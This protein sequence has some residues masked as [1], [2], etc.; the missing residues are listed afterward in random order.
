[1]QKII[2]FLCFLIQTA[3]FS[4]VQLLSRVQLFST[5]WTAA[6]QASLSFTIS[7]SLLKL[8]SIKSMMPSNHLILCHP[9]SSHLQSFPASGFFQMSQFFASGDQSIGASALA[10]VLPMN[11]LPNPQHQSYATGN[12]LSVSV[13]L[14]ILDI[15]RRWNRTVCGL[16][17]W[18]SHTYYSV[19]R[20]IYFAAGNCTS[21]LFI[22]LYAY[23]TNPLISL[24]AFG[25]ILAF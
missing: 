10:S 19:F 9:L 12:L 2:Y 13:A 21:F 15:L 14:P 1:M 17:W 20:Y 3:Q 18:A 25:W 11:T 5:P 8:M 23:T 7:W 22:P 16:L 6:C 24:W 4:S